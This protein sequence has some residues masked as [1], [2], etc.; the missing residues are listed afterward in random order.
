MLLLAHSVPTYYVC[1]PSATLMYVCGYSIYKNKIH[2]TFVY[3]GRQPCLYVLSINGRK[4]GP[5][6]LVLSCLSYF[7]FS[8]IT[9]WSGSAPDLF[10]RKKSG[11]HRHLIKWRRFCFIDRQLSVFHPS[12]VG[13]LVSFPFPFL[14]R[15]ACI[16]F[17]KRKEKERKSWEILLRMSYPILS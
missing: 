4:E 12:Q 5:T 11:C 15:G 7:S 2:G 3:L 9:D 14:A 1:A 16:G 17:Y 13:W 6:C 10:P 8:S